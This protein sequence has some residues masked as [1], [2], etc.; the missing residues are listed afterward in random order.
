MNKKEN[1][2]KS[3][4]DKLPPFATKV[5]FNRCLQILEKEA[6]IQNIY[7]DTLSLEKATISIMNIS[8]SKGGDYSFD[9]IEKFTEYYLSNKLFEKEECTY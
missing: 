9:V 7:L 6:K 3:M 5:D 2:S 1:I 8:Y 4:T